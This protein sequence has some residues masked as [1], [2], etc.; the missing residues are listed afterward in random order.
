MGS[1]KPPSAICKTRASSGEDFLF[2]WRS[3]KAPRFHVRLFLW[4]GGGLK[5]QKHLTT[6][7][8]QILNQLFLHLDFRSVTLIPKQNKKIPQPRLPSR[9]QDKLNGK[10]DFFSKEELN[11]TCSPQ[12]SNIDTQNCHSSKGVQLFQGP[13]LWHL[14]HCGMG[15][16]RR[17]FATNGCHPITDVCPKI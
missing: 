5:F 11:K 15:H 17:R 4:G 9:T 7:I 8:S 10:S 13:S 2:Q 12:K 3:K 14:Q 1:P 16:E 6:N